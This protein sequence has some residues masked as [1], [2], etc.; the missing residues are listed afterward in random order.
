MATETRL[1]IRMSSDELETL[2]TYAASKNKT[3]ADWV[4]ETLLIAAEQQEDKIGNLQARLEA[5]ERA[6]FH[7]SQ[8]A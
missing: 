4:R 8:A 2:K 5:L 1:S 3:L 7:N 6:V